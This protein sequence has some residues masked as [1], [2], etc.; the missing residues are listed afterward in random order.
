MR[1]SS[2]AFL[3]STLLAACLGC[4]TGQTQQPARPPIPQD[5]NL[6]KTPVVD[7]NQL[8]KSPTCDLLSDADLQ[9]VQ[10]EP[11]ADRQGTEHL[12]DALSMS[13]CFFRL[14]TFDKSVSLEVVRPKEGEQSKAALK[15][16][17]QQRFKRAEEEAARV[18]ELARR[19]QAE[20]EREKAE[21]AVREPGRPK[22]HKPWKEEVAPP[23]PVRGVGDKAFWARNSDGGAL[24]VLRKDL[25]FSVTLSGREAREV[26]IRTATE[27]AK[28]VLKNLPAGQSPPR[29]KK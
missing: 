5:G 24:F 12:S 27:L 21:G 7:P 4:G 25:F 10:G 22:R 18:A 23:Q 2:S 29:G 14:N 15:E 6:S 26:K 11:A 3:A 8:P 13:Q 17:W 28:R 19:Q 1:A 16:L 9:A 20:L